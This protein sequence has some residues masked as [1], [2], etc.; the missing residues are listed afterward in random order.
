MASVA[1]SGN[2]TLIINSYTFANFATGDVAMLTFPSEI[3]NVKTGKNG[4]SVYGL[5]ETG[6]QADLVVKVLRASADD[7]F[8]QGLLA[9]QQANFS[10]FIL[11]V[12]NLVKIVG[13][14]DGTISA[15]TYIISGGVFTK[16]IEAKINV[17]GDEQQSIS[18]YHMKFTN[19]PRVIT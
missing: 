16:Q 6:R 12:G 19:A 17:E 18:E 11:M 1:M 2:D 14:G 8:L 3:A 9:A 13:H 5:N 4:N 10:T 7:K 15:D